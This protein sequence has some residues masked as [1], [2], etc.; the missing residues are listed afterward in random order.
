MFQKIKLENTEN[1]SCF[2]TNLNKLWPKK[3][4]V[5]TIVHDSLLDHLSMLVIPDSLF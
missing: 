1:Y 2:L 5:E 3:G 4:R